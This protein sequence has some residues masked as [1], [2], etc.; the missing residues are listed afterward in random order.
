MK[1]RHISLIA[2]VHFLR[3]DVSGRAL[4]SGWR[5]LGRLAGPQSV[6]NTSRRSEVRKGIIS[7]V[8][9]AVAAVASWAMAGPATAAVPQGQQLQ[10]AALRHAPTSEVPEAVKHFAAGKHYQGLGLDVAQTRRIAAPDGGSWDVT[11]GNGYICLF[12]ESQETGAC[13]TTADALAGRLTFHFVTPSTEVGK[14]D[15]VPSDTPRFQVG[16]VP[17]G[18]VATTATARLGGSAVAARPNPDGLYR[19]SSNGVVGAVTMHRAGGRS[20][21]ITTGAK[22]PAVAHASYMDGIPPGYWSGYAYFTGQ[23]GNLAT[24]TDV[25]VDS[26]EGNTICGDAR[27][28]DQSWAGL[29]FCTA[30]TYVWLDHAYNG[31]HRYGYAGPG[32]PSASVYG[33]AREYYNS[34]G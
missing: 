5:R 27:N 19:L 6:T 11:P 22:K 21:L 26:L 33:A 2:A 3:K 14:R 28:P 31:S 30:T 34:L 9:V 18:V 8:V 10:F 13:A 15:S 20:R 16:L 23:Y 29:F 25:S 24:I 7:A 1:K 32:Y 4:R 12:V 17:D